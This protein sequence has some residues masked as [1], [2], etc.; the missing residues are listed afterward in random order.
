MTFPPEYTE[1]HLPECLPYMHKA[2]D[3]S[4]APGQM[5]MVLFAYNPSTWGKKQ[6]D[7]SPFKVTARYIM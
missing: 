6:Q 2:L 5:G 4:P 3:L 1:A 7:Q